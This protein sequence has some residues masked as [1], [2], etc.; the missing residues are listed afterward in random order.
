MTEWINVKD[1][2]PEKGAMVIG[3]TLCNKV[4]VF[5]CSEYFD[6]AVAVGGYIFGKDILYWMPLPEPPKECE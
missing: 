2:L 1:R 4:K 3:Y 6:D 5:R